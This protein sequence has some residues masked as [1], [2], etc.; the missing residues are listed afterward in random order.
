MT[1]IYTKTGDRGLTSLFDGTKVS[2][3]NIRVDS[4]GSVDELNSLLGVA[5]SFSKQKL[6]KKEIE[7]IQNDLLDIG[8]ALAVPAPLPVYDLPQR[9]GEFEVLIDKL[10]LKMPVLA[11]FILPSGGKGGSFLHLARSVSRRVERRI[12]ELS[13]KEEIDPEILIYLNRLSDLLFT[14]ARFENYKGKTSEKVWR[15]K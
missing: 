2:K 7:K 4:Y 1:K 14:F 10:T 8:S 13:K 6:I 12:V 3:A 15:K 9:V 11:S 5:A